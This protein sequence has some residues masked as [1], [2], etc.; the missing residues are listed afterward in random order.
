MDAALR[1]PSNMRGLALALLL[2]ALLTPGA[3]GFQG[4]G[5]RVTQPKSWAPWAPEEAS[6]T[7]TSAAAYSA[8]PVVNGGAKGRSYAPGSWGKAS[9]SSTSAASAA[10]AA[11]ADAFAAPATPVAVEVESVK[12][13]GRS[14]APWAPENSVKSSPSFAASV[15]FINALHVHILL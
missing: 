4:Q 12:V 11:F 14:W 7:A 5:A 1:S 9:S 15:S 2:C 3:E 10:S 6:S 8:A 13:E